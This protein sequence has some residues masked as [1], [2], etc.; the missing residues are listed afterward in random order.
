MVRHY[1]PDC[2]LRKFQ[3]VRDEDG[4]TH[5]GRVMPCNIHGVLSASN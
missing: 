2:F 3:K 4:I 1:T 5:L